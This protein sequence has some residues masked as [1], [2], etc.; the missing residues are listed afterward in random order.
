MS[1]LCRLHTEDL[2]AFHQRAI[3]RYTA[4]AKL[5]LRLDLT[6]GKP[7][8][9]QLD[10]SNALLEL[11]GRTDH[12]S[13][14]GGDCRNYYG[15]LR[16]LP[17]ARALFSGM[18]GA[19]VEQCLVGGN[20]SLALMHDAIVYA[21]LHGVPESRAA[22]SAEG[23]IAF[24]CPSPGYDRHFAICEAYGIRMIPVA[25]TGHGPDMAMVERLVG[26][27]PSIKGMWCVPKYSNPTG[28]IY[29]DE[30][31]ERL[32]SMRTAAPDFRL[33]WD[34]AYAVHHLTEKRHDIANIID[35]CARHGHAD[36]ALVFASTS[37]ITFAG[38]GLALFASSKE[39]LSW[40]TRHMGRRT[41]GADKLNQL[42]HVRM[43]R[44]AQGLAALMERH[45]QLLVPKFRAVDEIFAELLGGTGAASWTKPEGGYFVSLN[46]AQGCAKRVVDLG[47]AAGIAMVS[48]G[49]TFPY[50]RD[51]QDSN[52]RIAPSFA[53]V[54]EVKEAARGVALSVL[55]AAA[56][57]LL[58]ERGVTL[59]QADRK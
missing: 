53:P 24:L 49:Q 6:R 58:R 48:A 28:E 10:L 52:I 7:S 57:K 29:S 14:E 56:E 43:L 38:A 22:W 37:K 54:A 27:D 3:E 46:V 50:G 33:F 15:D 40:F 5:G 42:R 35:A 44:D 4:Y 36:R 31:V 16:G 55:R 39:N 59:N 30:T 13:A 19:P 45:R 23:P 17:E 9:E 25:L 51:P 47:R 32:A 34:N 26:D 11:P 1:E 12:I 41:I 21:L 8:P 20:S 18:L 2:V